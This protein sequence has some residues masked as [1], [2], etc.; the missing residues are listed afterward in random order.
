MNRR[1]FLAITSL[2]IPSI[3][4][5]EIGKVNLLSEQELSGFLF[6]LDIDKS[7][8]DTFK[9]I[10]QKRKPSQV[11]SDALHKMI[12]S[13]LNQSSNSE[14][15]GVSNIYNEHF[16]AIVR[17]VMG[18][19]HINGLGYGTDNSI[20]KRLNE[21]GIIASSPLHSVKDLD[22]FDKATWSTYCDNSSLQSLDTVGRTVVRAL[23]NRPDDMCVPFYVDDAL[24]YIL[25]EPTYYCYGL[26]MENPQKIYLTDSDK[27]DIREK[28]GSLPSIDYYFTQSFFFNGQNACQAVQEKKTNIFYGMDS[29]TS[30]FFALADVSPC[31]V[32]ADECNGIIINTDRPSIRN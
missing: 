22:T 32:P 8:K 10:M 2:S 16:E 5:G 17:P 4:L 28:T 1:N 13:G 25:Y 3:L 29:T 21:D 24:A 23:D 14:F 31:G 27:R 9:G 6:P 30:E 19:K 7:V 12:N 11:V 20:A 26:P 15:K 18:T